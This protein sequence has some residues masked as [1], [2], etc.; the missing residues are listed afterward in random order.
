MREA[1]EILGV[2]EKVQ[3]EDDNTIREPS[4]KRILQDILQ[5]L[6][7]FKKMDQDLGSGQPLGGNDMQNM[8]GM[9]K[10]FSSSFDMRARW[11]VLVLPARCCV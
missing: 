8:P 5:K 9:G 10:L 6:V 2:T 11:S 3:I 1:G 7:D 4:A